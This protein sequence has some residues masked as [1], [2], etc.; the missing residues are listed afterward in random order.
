MWMMGCNYSI[1]KVYIH[2]DDGIECSVHQEVT[3]RW[4]AWLERIIN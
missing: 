4:L 3:D 2:L 1:C